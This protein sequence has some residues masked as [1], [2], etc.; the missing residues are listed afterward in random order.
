LNAS[1]NARWETLE[2]IDMLTC[3]QNAAVAKEHIGCGKLVEESHVVYCPHC[4]TPFH[5]Q[6]LETHI[7]QWKR[8]GAQSHRPRRE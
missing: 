6:C 8:W 4:K 2:R 3:G 5:A 1:F 7:A